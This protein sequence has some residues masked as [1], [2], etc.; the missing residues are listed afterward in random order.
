[1]K[2][3]QLMII[4]CLALGTLWIMPNVNA[5]DVVSIDVTGNIIA[6]PCQVKGDSINIPVDLGQNIGASTLQGFSSA[7]SWVPITVNLINC[8]A[9]TNKVTMLFQGTADSANPNDMYQNAGTATNLAVQLQGTGG[10]Q[11][12]NG[13]SFIG[14]IVNNA[15]TYRLQARA[16]S[17]NGNVVPGTI[18]AVVTAT[19]T[20]Q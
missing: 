19:F 9:G 14:N 17:Q 13:K 5:A 8:P 7:T 11:L 12:G 10:E 3:K 20:Y 6:S 16:Y 15:Y 4:G 18:S 1:M 2:V